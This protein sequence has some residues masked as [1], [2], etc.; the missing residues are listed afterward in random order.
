MIVLFNDD[1]Y[2]MESETPLSRHY[3]DLSLIIRPDMRQYQLLD[4]MIEFKY[5]NLKALGLTAEMVKTMSLDELKDHPL[6][7]E[8]IT[9]AQVQ[10]QPYQHSL[11]E[12][13]GSQLRL[14]THVVVAL[15]FERLVSEP[16]NLT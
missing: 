9:Q 7:Q 12:K 14:H 1:F 3:A 10:L 6:V 11:M 2:M 4:H 13:Y 16:L 5:L 15:G 8:Q